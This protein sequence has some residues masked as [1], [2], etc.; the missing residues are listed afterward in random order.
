M[1]DAFTVAH[2]A[3]IIS[4]AARNNV[5]AVIRYLTLPETAV[6]SLAVRP[7]I[8]VRTDEQIE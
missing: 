8:L 3:L 1:S 6:C 2:R 5:P 4:A 7:S